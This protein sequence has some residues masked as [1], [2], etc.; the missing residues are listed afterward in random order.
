[1]NYYHVDDIKKSLKSLVDASAN[2]IQEVT[3]IG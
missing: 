3:D 2:T 1:M